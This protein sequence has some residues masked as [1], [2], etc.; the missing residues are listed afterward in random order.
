MDL[1]SQQ[2]MEFLLNGLK[3]VEGICSPERKI[4]HNI[5][6]HDG[7]NIINATKV[8]NTDLQFPYPPKRVDTLLD[9][10][11]CYI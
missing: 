9:I 2:S 4:L 3:V 7:C 8:L 1:G 10:V 11:G 6:I 5:G